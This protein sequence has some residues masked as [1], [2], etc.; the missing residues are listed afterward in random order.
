MPKPVPPPQGG[1]GQSW[2]V[3]DFE[4]AYV[5][6]KPPEFSGGAQPPGIFG[7]AF[8]REDFEWRIP[9]RVALLRRIAPAPE[10]V[11]AQ[12]GTLHLGRRRMFAFPGYRAAAERVLLVRRDDEEFLLLL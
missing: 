8:Q 1:Q 2:F 6:Y 10:Y 3:L 11:L 7:P 4:A 5:G 9:G 12:A